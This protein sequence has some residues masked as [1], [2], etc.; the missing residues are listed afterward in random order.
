MCW[1]LSVWKSIFFSSEIF[2]N[3]A[4]DNLLYS[5]FFGVSVVV[6]L[7]GIHFIFYWTSYF[8]KYSLSHFLWDD[9]VLSLILFISFYLSCVF[10][11]TLIVFWTLSL[12]MPMPW[13]LWP[14]GWGIISV[15]SV[16]SLVYFDTPSHVVGISCGLCLFILDRWHP[17]LAGNSKWEW[18]CHLGLHSLRGFSQIQHFCF[19]SGFLLAISI[20]G[21]HYG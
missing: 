5:L 19:F 12:S 11:N 9:L 4:S 21:T 3:I 2:K 16:P 13:L 10:F 7:H 1:A 6:D 20:L 14:P 17:R 8:T 15:Y 18:A